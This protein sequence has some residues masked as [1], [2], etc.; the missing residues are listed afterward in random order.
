MLLNKK[1]AKRIKELSQI[2][3]E[4]RV[5][6][7]ERVKIGQKQTALMIKAE[8]ESEFFV[9]H[10]DDGI[11]TESA[12][13]IESLLYEIGSIVSELNHGDEK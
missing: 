11:I 8:K 1:D 12:R 3:N 2:A 5:L 10:G 7:D 9:H 4:L 13:C 6:A